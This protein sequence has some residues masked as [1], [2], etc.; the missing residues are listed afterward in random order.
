[1]RIRKIK[2]KTSATQPTS[3]AQFDLKVFSQ[4]LRQL[5]DHFNIKLVSIGAM[6]TV[7]SE[8]NGTSYLAIW[9]TEPNG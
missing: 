9:A 8:T 3:S 6:A 2:I 1:M 5:S 4:E 7:D